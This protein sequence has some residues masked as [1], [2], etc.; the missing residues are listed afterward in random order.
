MTVTGCHQFRLTRNADLD[1]SDDVEDLA[2]ALEGELENRRFGAKV[3]RSDHPLPT[4]DGGLSAWR[5][6]FKPKSNYTVSMVLS[7]WRVC[8]LI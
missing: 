4:A 1:L 8:C 7:I 6:W 5:V 3:L 2:K